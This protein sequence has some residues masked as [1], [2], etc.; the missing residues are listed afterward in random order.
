MEV[1]GQTS[2]PVID[3]LLVG[4]AGVPFGLVM[5]KQD[6]LVFA[7]DTKWLRDSLGSSLVFWKE[8]EGGHITF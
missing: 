7:S 5:A 6:A 2:A 1:Y 8:I 4:K 3:P